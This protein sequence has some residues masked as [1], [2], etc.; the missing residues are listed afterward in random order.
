[1]RRAAADDAFFVTYWLHHLGFPLCHLLQPPPATSCS[2][3][4]LIALAWLLAV[5]GL[6]HPAPPPP[7]PSSSSVAS[8]D[9]LSLFHSPIKLRPGSAAAS[10][11][12]RSPATSTAPPRRPAT[13]A[14]G[15]GVGV[16][17]AAASSSHADVHRLLR[18]HGAAVTLLREC[19]RTLRCVAALQTS[20]AETLAAVPRSAAAP[21]LSV[22][23]AVLLADA[24]AMEQHVELLQLRWGAVQV[25]YMCRGYT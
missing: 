22:A 17:G 23:D 24:D 16:G 12:Q 10:R 25:V 11:T 4:L 14:G 21:P 8:S 9:P 7:P 19:A 1:V 3:A 13:A 18:L 6:T 5:A 2:R 20:C 15:A